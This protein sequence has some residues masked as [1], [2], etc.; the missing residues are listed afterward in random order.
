MTEGFF[1]VPGES[2]QKNWNLESIE[3]TSSRSWTNCVAS[4]WGAL[5]MNIPST[6]WISCGIFQSG[7]VRIG[8]NQQFCEI[9]VSKNGVCIETVTLSRENGA[10][11]WTRSCFNDTH[12][13]PLVFWNSYGKAPFSL[14]HRTK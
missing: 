7:W 4:V 6:I 2:C 1:A 3:E 11:S 12:W 13:I 10:F 8:Y 5:Q 9:A 14:N